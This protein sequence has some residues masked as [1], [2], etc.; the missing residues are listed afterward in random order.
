MAGRINHNAA[1]LI[2][3]GTGVV[4]GGGYWSATTFTLGAGALNITNRGLV[5]ADGQYV[6]GGGLLALDLT[7]GRAPGSAFVTAGAATLG[8]TLAVT[9]LSGSAGY[10][11]TT[12]PDGIIY[13][14]DTKASD[15]GRNQQL[16]IHTQNGVG[17]TWFDHVTLSGGTSD[18][19]YLNYGVTLVGGTDVVAGAMLTWYTG[20]ET[21]HGNFTITNTL[22][23]FDVDVALVN[24]SP[25]NILAWDGQS[26]T[27]TAS[28]SGT[29]ILSASNSYSGTTTV[30]GGVLS[31][32]GWT[33]STTA[34]VVGSTA[35]LSGTLTVSGSAWLGG[36]DTELYIGGTGGVGALNVSGGVVNYNEAWLGNGG[37]ASF[38]LSGGTISG[39]EVRM[40]A[41]LGGVA[42]GTISG[43]LWNTN[44][45]QFE[46]GLVNDGS[47][48][49]TMTGGTLATGLLNIGNFGRGALT[50][51]GGLIEAA[52]F[53][54]VGL[55][56]SFFQY[57]P[58]TGVVTMTGG[59]IN[60]ALLGVGMSGSGGAA[61][62][63]TGTVSLSG[64]AVVNAGDVMLGLSAG[65]TGGMSVSGG[66]VLNATGGVIVGST[67]NLFAAS[68]GDGVGALA[69]SDSGSVTAGGTYSQNAL[70]TLTL[71]LDG[72][73]GSRGAFITASAADLTSA[74]T[75]TVNA[76]GTAQFVNGGSASAL[77]N[78]AQIL[79]HTSTI[80]GDFATKTVTGGTSQRDFLTF[81]AFI[82][83]GTDYVAGS[84]LTWYSGTA[85]AHG[86][87]T[88][89]SGESFTLDAL[90]VNGTGGLG[91]V[92]VNPNNTSAWDGDTLTLT[93]SN[94][95]TLILSATNYLAGLRV[96]GGWLVNRGWTSDDL[97]VDNGATAINT[98]GAYLTATNAI[99]GDTAAGALLVEGGTVSVL[100]TLTVGAQA[101]SS[102]TVAVNGSGVLVAGNTGAFYTSVIGDSGVG[103]LNLGGD[104][105]AFFSS[106]S[107]GLNGGGLT[108][109]VGNSSGGSGTV[110]VSDNA[111]LSVTS[112]GNTAI[113]LG[114]DPGATGY[115]N[116]S[117]G[118]V[119]SVAGG[120]HDIIG[121][122]GG[123]GY[124]TVSGSGVWQAN[125]IM[126]GLWGGA[127]GIGI[128]SLGVLG[129]TG[130]GRVS[131]TGASAAGA[132]LAVGVD[133]G[134]SGTVTVSGS[135]WLDAGSQVIIGGG[136]DGALTVSESG[137]LTVSGEIL[138]G[139]T[140]P[141]IMPG[142]T[143]TGHGAVTVSG[144][145]FVG[146]TGDFTVGEGGTGAL[147]LTGNGR[148]SSHDVYFG[149]S[150]TA[151]GSGT[152]SGSAFWANNGG[153]FIVGNYGTG[154]LT[155]T[156][157]GSITSGEVN[158]GHYAGAVGSATVSGTAFWNVAGDFS[159]GNLATATGNLAI[160]DSGSIALTQQY[161]QNANSSLTLTLTDTLGYRGAFI[162]ADEASLSGT[163]TVNATGTANFVSGGSAAALA[164]GAQVL[165][166]TENGFNNRDFAS[167][168]VTGGTSQRDFLTFGAFITGGTDYVLGS[169]LAWFSA[170][171]ASHG[172]FTL[173]S[174]E[175]F[176][177]DVSL[178][179]TTA[180]AAG[181]NVPAWDGKSLTVTSSNQGTLYLTASNN[182]TGTTFV[183]GGAL[184]V[185][186][187]TGGSNG[188]IA[189]SSETLIDSGGTLT[190][191]GSGWLNAIDY[192]GLAG[193]YLVVGYNG[194]G[195]LNLTDSGSVTVEN[196]VTLGDLAGSTGTASVSGGLLTTNQF[197]IGNSGTGLLTISGGTVSGTGNYYSSLGEL[198]DGT[199]I[200][201]MRGGLLEFASVFLVGFRG[202]GELTLSGGTLSVG[203]AS[204][205]G[206]S[207]GSSGT[208]A[209]SGGL[210][211]S[212]GD[213]LVG[214][215]STGALTLSGGTISA[216]G[217][218]VLG[219]NAI[220]TATVSGSGLWTVAGDFYNGY[221]GTGAL[222]VT[223][224]GS[225]SVGGDIA[226]GVATTGTGAVSVRGS[227]L[228]S[229]SGNLYLGYD[230]SGTLGVGSLAIANSG[231]VAVTGSYV[232]TASSALALT[233]DGTL[234][235]RGAFVTAQTATV[236]GT[237]SVSAAGAA[238]DTSATLASH[239]ADAAQ[240][241]IHTTGGVTVTASG[242][243]SG[244]A[245][246]GAA[247]D[248]LTAG[249]F[250]VGGTDYVLGAQLAWFG[251]T[252][253]GY[254]GFT[255]DPNTSFNVNVTLSD[256]MGLAGSST[257]VSGWDGRSLTVTSSNSGTLILSA[258][259]TYTGSTTV[260]GGVL[261]V[262]G[263]TGSTSQVVIGPNAT[264]SGTVNVNGGLLAAGGDF[265]VGNRG[266]GLLALTAGG[267]INS[268]SDVI[269]GNHQG[270]RGEVTVS[271]S[272]FWNS[273]RD[274]IVG[275]IGA[276]ALTLTESG[277]LNAGRL[278]YLGNS[279]NS[280]GVVT[281]SG[282]ARLTA[283]EGLYV[284]NYGTGTLTLTGNGRIDSGAA[285]IGAGTGTGAATVG[286]SAYWRVDDYISVG[287]YGIGALTLAESGS[288]SGHRIILGN[289]NGSA[290]TAVVGGTARLSA[291]ED[292]YN[293]YYMFTGT[294]A[295]IVSGSGLVTVGGLYSQSARSTLTLDASGRGEND[296]FIY[297][298]SATVGGAI[299]VGGV[300]PG[301][302]FD[303]ASAVVS[304]SH[305]VLI[306]AT[307]GTIS[308]TFA[309]AT[310]AGFNGASLPDYLYGGIYKTADAKQYVAGV[311]LAWFGDAAN[312]HGN[313][314]V[315]SGTSFDV[316]VSLSDTNNFVSSGTYAGGWDGKSLTVTSSNSGTLILSASNNY[317]GTTTVN[318]GVL[319]ITGWTGTNAAG[320]VNG[321][322]VNVSGN[323]YWGVNHLTV[324]DATAGALAI[325]GS[326]A[327]ASQFMA[328]NTA[329]GSGAI[330]VSG[331]GVLTVG[332]TGANYISALGHGAGASGVLGLGDDARVTISGS[333]SPFLVGTAG[334]SGTVTISGRAV[335]ALVNLQGRTGD[336]TNAEGIALGFGDDSAGYLFI[337]GGTLDTRDTGFDSIGAGM[338][339]TAGSGFATVSGSGVWES[340]ALLAGF[341]AN[342]ADGSGL[343]VVTV[344]G[345]GR[346]S[347]AGYDVLGL[348]LGV[349]L[350]GG[351]SG[352]V[353]ISGGGWYDAGDRVVFGASGAG[354]LTVGQ[355]GSLTADSDI[356]IGAALNEF[357]YGSG[358]GGL[359][360]VSVSGSGLVA[361][362]SNFILG[363]TSG[364][365]NL[366]I[367]GSGLVTAGGVYAQNAVSSLTLTLDGTPGSR[368]AFV[369]ANSGTL[370]GTLTVNATGT[371]TFVSGGSASA[372]ANNAQVLI[373]TNTI[374]GDFATVS[375]TGG[376]SQ[377]DFLTF[378]AFITGGTDYV[379]GSQLAWFSATTASHGN[380][381][382]GAGESF[383]VDVTLSDTTPHAA[384]AN[385]I[386]W[387]G[388][389]LTV[390]ST[391]TGNL[392]LSASNNYS[393]TTTVNGGVL[394]I[395]GYVGGTAGVIGGAANT[396]GAVTISGT[397]NT[398][399]NSTNNLTVGDSGTGALT[400]LAGGM[401]G[402]NNGYLGYSN[403]GSGSATVA[404]VW[405]NRG[406]LTV[407]DR[408]AGWLDILAGGTVT[409]SAGYVGYNTNGSGSAT[410]AGVWANSGNLVVGRWSAG[411]LNILAGGTVTNSTGDV[412]NGGGG[413][414]SATV[415]GVW[416][417]R[418]DLNVGNNGTG[419]LDI[420]AG[421]TV[422]AA[423]GYLGR[424]NGSSGSANVAGVWTNSGDFTV[425]YGGKGWL[426]VTDS[427][428]VRAGGNITVGSGASTVIVSDT[429]LVT[430]ASNFI[431][432]SGGT[433]ALTVS[434]SGT[435]AAGGAYSQNSVSMLTI[436]I[437]DT[438]RTGAYIVA[439]TATLGGSLAV[440][441][442]DAS[443]TAATAGA[444]YADHT[445]LMH[446]TGG[447]I[448]GDFTGKNLD[449]AASARNYLVADAYKTNSGTDYVAGYKL[450]WYGDD[451]HATGS[452][453]L[454]G[455]ETFTVDN[456]YG[457]EPEITVNG[458]GLQ[459]RP[460]SPINGWDGQS[461]TKTGDGTLILSATNT[462][463][464]T[465]F[466]N[467]GALSVSGW[468]GSTAQVVI[469][470]SAGTSG[471]VS[472]SGYLNATGGN[473]STGII[474][475]SNGTGV[476]N[477]TGTVSGSIN[478]GGSWS[479]VAG[480]SNGRGA[481]N[482]SDSGYLFSATQMIA[483]YYGAGAVNLTG[484]GSIRAGSDFWISYV[485][486]GSGAVSVGGNALLDVGGRLV[487]GYAGTQNAKLNITD[488][489][490]VHAAGN[491]TVGGSHSMYGYTTGTV[492]VSGSGVLA[493]DA[494]F[495]L[496]GGDMTVSGADG[497][498]TLTITGSG[499]VTA[500][501]TY[502]QNARSTL[503]VSA[504]SR[505]LGDA[506]IYASSAT[507]S[508]TII[509]EDFATGTAF[510]DA[511]AVQSSSHQLL[512]STTS[513]T[514]SGV[515]TSAT[516]VNGGSNLPDYL[517]GGVYKTTSGSAYVAGVNLSWLGDT[518]N[519]TGNFT[520]S[521]GTFNVNIA[522]SDTMGLAGSSTY[523]NNWDGRSL[524][525]TSTNTGTLILSASNSYTGSTSVLGGN[526]LVTTSG[527]AAGIYNSAAALIDGGA[528]T[529]SGSAV[530]NATGGGNSFTVGSATTGALTLTDSGS[531]GTR[532]NFII[533]SATS[534]SGTVSL[535]GTAAL[536]VATLNIGEN[537]ALIVGDS[538]TG[539]LTISDAAQ[540][541]A[542][543][544]VL[545]NGTTGSGTV[546]LGGSG[547]L[548]AANGIRVGYVGAGV[549]T[550]TNNAVINSG[551]VRVGDTATGS[552]TV[553]VG[554]SA[555]WNMS[556]ISVGNSGTGWL[557]LSGGTLN[558][559][560]G[561]SIGSDAGSHG[562]ATVSGGLWSIGTDFIVGYNG[563][564]LLSVSGGTVS[565]GGAIALGVYANSSGSV[566]LSGG[567]LLT[568]S[569]NLFNGE[570]GA[571]SL[572]VSDT[573]HV[574][575][576]GSYVQSGSSSLTLTLSDTLGYRDAFVSATAAQLSGTLTVNA[577]GTA[578]FVNGGSASALANGA[579]ILI[580]TSA[581]SGDF[582][583]VTVNGGTGA[584]DFLNFGAFITGGTDYV[585]GSQ[586]AWFSATTA[587]HGNFTLNSGESF[588]VDV[589]LSNTTA[590]LGTA[591]A[592]GATWD[593]RSLTVT[594]SNSGT[595]IL[596]ASNSYSGTT[597]VL[598]GALAITGW[599][600][601][602]AQVTIGAGA[603]DSGTVSVSG[604]L[605][606][607]N[608]IIVGGS[609]AGVLN[610]SNSG[611]VSAGSTA[612][613][614]YRA[615]ATGTVNVSGSGWLGTAS[616]LNVGARGAGVLNLTGSGSVTVG[617]S[618]LVGGE[619][620]TSNAGTGAVTV[621]DSALLDVLGEINIGQQNA[622]SEGALTV[623]GGIVHGH[624]SVAIG[625]YSGRG[626]ATVSG[627]LLRADNY[628]TIGSYDGTGTL[629][630]TG[631]T[632]STGN[633][634]SVE[635][636]SAIVSGSGFMTSGSALRVSSLTSPV[637]AIRESGS[638]SVA[639]NVDMGNFGTG[640]IEVS[641]S[642]LLAGAGNF[643]NGSTGTGALTVSGSGLVTAS[644]VYSQN[645]VSSLTLDASVRGLNDAFIYASSATV[646][647]TISVSGFGTGGN[648]TTAS[649]VLSGSRQV[650]ISATGAGASGTIS[651]VF[652]SSTLV[653]FAG[654]LPD[655]LYGGIYKTTDAKQY[656]AGVNLAWF[657]DA[658]NGHGNFSVASGTSFDVNVTLSD[659]M[660][661]AGSSTYVSNW[662]GRSLTVTSSNS[663]TLILSGS[664]N[665]TGTTTVNGGVLNITGW[666]GSTAEVIIGD[667]TTDSG[668]VN[669]NG[670]GYLGAEGSI[671]VGREGAGMLLVNGGTVLAQGAVSFGH[672]DGVFGSGSVAGG[673]LAGVGIY[674]GGGSSGTGVLVING[675]TVS[676]SNPY[677]SG[678]VYIGD[679]GSGGVTLGGNGLLDGSDNS[680]AVGWGG[681]TGS[682]SMSSG[683]ARGHEVYIGYGATGTVGM[684][685][686]LLL[687]TENTDW[688][689]Y[690]GSNSGT[691]WL[692]VSGGTAQS[693]GV[694]SIGGAVGYGSGYGEVAISGS[695]LMT[696]AGNLSVG[697]ESGTGALTIS[698][699][700]L[701]T[702]GGTYF[703]NGV[704][705]LNISIGGT[706]GAFVT[707]AAAVLDNTTLNVLGYTGTVGGLKASELDGANQ[708][709][710]HT[711][712]TIAGD[713]AT[714]NLGG[715]AST[716]DYLTI[717][718]EKVNN[719]ADYEIGYN[720]TWLTG[721]RTSHG[722]FTLAAG[723][724]FEVDVSLSTTTAH[725][726]GSF[727]PAWDGASLTLTAVN[728]GLLTLSASNTYTGT[729]TVNGGTLAITGWT[730]STAAV[731]V[732]GSAGIPARVD[733]SGGGYLG[734]ANGGNLTVGGS[735]AGGLN[736]ASTGT[737]LSKNNIF[738]GHDTGALGTGTVG[739]LLTAGGDLHVGNSGTGSLDIEATGTVINGRGVIGSAP[740]AQG[741]VIVRG[742]WTNTGALIVGDAGTG[743]LMVTGTGAAEAH[744]FVS[745]G[746]SGIGT[747]TVSG[748]G[749]L[750]AGADLVLGNEGR[751]ALTVTDS[752]SVTTGTH[753][754]I[755]YNG[756]GSL[757]ISGTGLVTAGGNFLNGNSG[758]GSLSI[759]GSGSVS[760]G[761]TYSQSASSTLSLDLSTRGLNDAFI[762]AAAAA[763]DGGLIVA[764]YTG[765]ASGTKASE[766]GN[767]AQ[768]LI[769]TT[770]TITGDFDTKAITGGTS[771]VD[772][773]THSAYVSGG[774]NYVIGSGLTWQSGT[775]QAHG[776]FTVTS[777]TFEVDV[778]LADESSGNTSGWNGN[779][780]IK[781]GQ[782]TLVL[783]ASNSYSGSTSVQ[784]GE[785]RVTHTAALGAGLV[786]IA[787]GAVLSATFNSV[788]D[789][790][791]SNTLNGSGLLSVDLTATSNTF[792]F[793]PSV[794]QSG[795]FTGTARLSNLAYTLANG[796]L[797]AATLVTSTGAQVDVATGTHTLAGLAIDGG[798]VDF[799]TNVPA[800]IV[801]PDFIA[802]TGTIRLVS[803]TVGVRIPTGTTTHT[804]PQSPL[805]QQ[806]EGALTRLASSATTIGAPNNI[807]LVD[808]NT[809]A[810][811]T[812]T[813]AAAIVQ[814]GTQVAT[815]T[816]G[817][818]LSASD[819][820]GNHGL[821]A[822]Y[823][824]VAVDI[825]AGRTLLLASDTTAPYDGDEFHAVISGS[826]NLELDATQ[827][828][829]LNAANS[830]TGT[831]TIAGGTII[832]G[833]NDALGHTSWLSVTS[834]AAYDL[835]ANTQTIG[836]GIIAGGLQGLSTGSLGLGGSVDIT[837]TNAGFAASVGVT[838]TTTLH[839][840]HA[841]GDSGTL[842]I[843]HA[844]SVQLI[845]STGTFSKIIS[846][847]GQFALAAGSTVA[848]TGSNT[849]FGGTF[850]IAQDTALGAGS[851]ANLGAAAI[852]D[853]GLLTL[854]NTAAE[855]LANVLGGSGTFVK[856]G[857]GNLTISQSNAF[858]GVTTVAGGTLTLTD[859]HGVGAGDI[860]NHATLDLAG[861]G[862]FANNLLGTGTTIIDPDVILTGSNTLAAWDVTS[863][864]TATVTQQQN[865]GDAATRIDGRLVI[866]ATGGWN[867]GNALSGTGVLSVDTSGS[868]FAFAGSTGTA[869]HGTLAL[870]HSAFDLSGDNT[871]A[872][873]DA[874][875]RLDAASH[876]AV[877]TGTQQIGNLVLGSGTI[878]F[879]L[880]ASG[881]QADGIVS[882]GVLDIGDTV[883]RIDTGS[884]S[885]NNSSPILQQDEGLSLQLIASDTLAAGSKTLVTGS[886]LVDQTGAEISQA[887]QNNIV[888]SG[889]LTASGTYNFA[890]VAGNTGLHLAYTLTDLDLLAGRTTVLDHETA[891]LGAITGGTTPGGH[892]L[893]AKV[894]GS[895]NLQIT[896]TGAIWLNNA[897]NAYSGTTLVTSGTLVAGA[898]GALG[899]TGYL[900]IAAGA[901]L[902]LNHTAQ[903]IG[904]G[905]HVAG[906]DGLQGTGTL[907]LA[908]GLFDVLASNTGFAALVNTTG[909]VRLAHVQSLGA[910]GAVALNSAAATLI[911]DPAQSGTFATAFTGSQGTFI[912]DGASTVTIARANA[913]GGDAQIRTGTLA[914]ADI[915]A[916]G[917]ASV[918]ISAGAA[919][920]Y[921]GIASGAS[922]NTFSGSG[923]LSVISSTLTL[924]RDNTMA[925]A[926]LDNAVV[927]MSSS[928]ALG[929]AA[930]VVTLN[931][932][933][934][935]IR[936][937]T[938]AA[939]L[940]TLHLNGGALAFVAPA[941]FAAGAA[942]AAA[943]HRARIG[944]LG[945][946]AGRFELN[947]DFTGAAG[948]MT[949]ATGMK[950]NSLAITNDAAGTHQVHI[951]HVGAPGGQSAS[952]E[953][954]TTGS[955]LAEFVLDTNNG[956]IDFGLTA[957][958]LNRGDDTALMP[959]ANNWYLADTGLSNAA[960]VILDTASTIP[961]DWNI[962]LDALH[963]R[964]GEVRA[965]N[966]PGTSLNSG[967]GA[968]SSGNL[969]VRS[970][971]YRL[972]ATNSI[973]GRGFDQYGWG[974]TAGMDKRFR[975]ENAANLL[976]AFIDAGSIHR[977]FDLRGGNTSSSVM[978]GAYLTR[979]HDN[980][981][982]ADAVVRA[983]RY[984]NRID[985]RTPEL[986]TVQGR[987]TSRAL[988]GSVE[989]GRRLQRADGWWVEPALQASILW[990]SGESFDTSPD[991]LRLH[992]KQDSLRSAQYRALVRFGRQLGDSRWH[993]YGKL[994]AAA[995][996]SD[997]GALHAHDKHLSPTYD[998]KR[999]EFGLGASYRIND[1000]SQMYLDYEY[1001]RARY[1002]ERPWSINLGYRRL[1003]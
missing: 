589:T 855:T 689:M 973:T 912:K 188:M 623:T 360:T 54:D 871:A 341:A 670:S 348:A 883:I 945:A 147:L 47:A 649:A 176:N 965:E 389:S 277:S 482:V 933:A 241:L 499:L 512:I 539:L 637:L 395:S 378:G 753:F 425:G 362:A 379:L 613:V 663:G 94:S 318:G 521:G 946:S 924:A 910:T 109:V 744:D 300:G 834:T 339:A 291:G 487:I 596:S 421:G 867:Y 343:G 124:A 977:D 611:S 399:T 193:G 314:S 170:T 89:N 415:A 194:F 646:G 232:Q 481:I 513:G 842:A 322:T 743:A 793:G 644:G 808:L 702:A 466:V 211:S 638:V 210:W 358:D 263:W 245:G 926:S 529:V 465:T 35:G 271:G 468:T 457:V 530:W 737:A 333:E 517:Y 269:L 4:S 566:S 582:A 692:T 716:L 622:A 497:K 443:G 771:A 920:E 128:N 413:S 353:A 552:G 897:A 401:V 735:G 374:S 729:T 171:T 919:F 79:I 420:L 819:S 306:S 199:G 126:V 453:N 498:G 426:K 501:G 174:G 412:G 868:A 338:G 860:T 764:N 440:T 390:T 77:A 25:S 372:L 939:Q 490:T 244:I 678:G 594:S 917:T 712:G 754:A 528:A 254:G 928:H 996:D 966:L 473:N 212:G 225:V 334:G 551:L 439:Q 756:L 978:L 120:G 368:S 220:G 765:T 230:N 359:G 791:F 321:G 823:G 187:T 433:G 302:N 660:G 674:F 750:S 3:G 394:A 222:A 881:T 221:Y 748:S 486:S 248:Y 869:F 356:I 27:L 749:W 659:T 585:L 833:A 612:Y 402:D 536:G 445:L 812:A 290:G 740:D 403:G 762:T 493:A 864:G 774:T 805:L 217:D 858:T 832:A 317:T 600:G 682:L 958:E 731:V 619:Y 208:A 158:I 50:M 18:F 164:N 595:L 229:G 930:T 100:E 704:S 794:F 256:T 37:T 474:V 726:S 875:L 830:Y 134:A 419:R 383:D 999:V 797:A 953:L 303:N 549:F 58:G 224:S 574:I 519:G 686:G 531:I 371:A 92:A 795:L 133:G 836:G 736:I 8:G 463:T 485:S 904:N 892:E 270:G 20:T 824:L 118:T 908:G 112:V 890:G 555:L 511:L 169:E 458:I 931:N 902:N 105:S 558:G 925:F 629:A 57:G 959:G 694:I 757:D 15:V 569:G 393:G 541:A 721:T 814:A 807:A 652:V 114:Y 909:T 183:L 201:D 70:S 759:A 460:A 387:D 80:S 479:V 804:V 615:D 916:L 620:Y 876:T 253:N 941:N 967:G 922:Q 940:G 862:I 488:S 690:I 238:L 264:D 392:I 938:P 166:H 192:G 608:G 233:L 635:H 679:G 781:A 809:G 504:S 280:V 921:R 752:G 279:D 889:T 196:H 69:V 130:G 204:Y 913:F 431:L 969:W 135:G 247:R 53:M 236:G 337:S 325:T 518:N 577:S 161:T 373:H 669:V 85:T 887:T 846:G 829:T 936:I 60:T 848:L 853:D 856:D 865:L 297:A 113:S 785:L 625:Y 851:T 342:G 626:A 578:A 993:P 136:G 72:T 191:S 567:G 992:V 951:N 970:R 235:S 495:Y 189:A 643:N 971:A 141:G 45:S 714:V 275:G 719:G 7:S 160:S 414:G 866:T 51:T 989:A 580:H 408:G 41:N 295:L 817:Y 61:A 274:F 172:N 173:N 144:S 484:S 947:V 586:L 184:I 810:L 330:N 532:G 475:G 787:G 283:V 477:V 364:T 472:V 43:G 975:T 650:L 651:G 821:Y 734:T 313:F 86:D 949:P 422:S 618:L 258:S 952:F 990:L 761:G 213:F 31:V 59:T 831:T 907:T 97:Y 792:A 515:F 994:G 901:A 825:L 346:I 847:S 223:D 915:A 467:G 835:A 430:T 655:Y 159:V 298:A 381:T 304:S 234:G 760:V 294:G 142:L 492:T 195:A 581:I 249:L 137:S 452:F 537:G 507:V 944:T 894:T 64:G 964:M 861:D 52:G 242:T 316:N 366:A 859:L 653:G 988:G 784:V 214:V 246:V 55:G 262:T 6:Q 738:F 893:H 218:A 647:G 654:G 266:T 705:G 730:G 435:V 410:V 575:L 478:G 376:T 696:A 634:F 723:E 508:G 175:S 526:L 816:Y 40:G 276:G 108:L 699:S 899:N 888:Q 841:L 265:Y 273:A 310:L 642:G 311:N 110:S 28:N 434:D 377:R 13:L 683:T 548:T 775:D 685:G 131:L 340:R 815:G 257:Y 355:S 803:G 631:G 68:L 24:Q 111:L 715:A 739:G 148:I 827:S 763:L 588:N 798:R 344:T 423:T 590:D 179:N 151:I 709:V 583:S 877:G 73:L 267:V 843:T 845:G 547:Q 261:E 609:G 409:N 299:T 900:D 165:I 741:D 593:G 38:V 288:L 259:N 332:G 981:W 837:S 534:A 556:D 641:G 268:G 879:A 278:V 779:S 180:H 432:G 250:T 961:L 640:S 107:G 666:T 778:T 404:G 365:G 963:L 293:G 671:Y 873:A 156:D 789:Y 927:T 510:A 65:G 154:A 828:I 345:N 934:S 509:V 96:L 84:Q 693:L 755:G 979:L 289:Y 648:F 786:D 351:N 444:I 664:N 239:L 706:R 884:F 639:G 157:S 527:S 813:Q 633:Y 766:L 700:G 516:I 36:A 852:A 943:Y 854:S 598:G 703:Q 226:I 603:A 301:G 146:V 968:A 424:V 710:I 718:G 937:D 455:G 728:E 605:G 542:T 986:R 885:G 406:S 125:T 417:N 878:T 998:G 565:A 621:G 522:L 380:F 505:G 411:W 680:F 446:M 309:T 543:T 606:A 202:A 657:G 63:G 451:T 185:T 800:D 725:A 636:G 227:A 627:G 464:G 228:L 324:G 559:S 476:L 751:G 520:V 914:A 480:Y 773:L 117:G 1003:W 370:G 607:A 155:L 361:T 886:H 562:A 591:N 2:N 354:G 932:A 592:S 1002:Y 177:V 116:V 168:I 26:L 32:T 496:G 960:D 388:R 10:T 872:L 352:T 820:A 617:S 209:V 400:I 471:T 418:N 122:M 604:Y 656:V 514:I 801:S 350:G 840:T 564:G 982:F 75:L 448:R 17:G 724:N 796:D 701:V 207:A 948:L 127:Q 863:T 22:G 104:A 150:A 347:A 772:Y 767:N 673:Y 102:G 695:G 571:G 71:T 255:L 597:S 16:L 140:G 363:S 857:A 56:L 880:G 503:T 149:D 616:V 870:G 115:L 962:A 972:N 579:Q 602:T 1001:A 139:L 667:T 42:T 312:G 12:G 954:I 957:Y 281:V 470:G 405:A 391:N 561:A 483:G 251:D 935:A 676:G 315:A 722:N 62:P 987:Y 163:L 745:F 123:S 11:G 243:V 898:S 572:T 950:A 546:S 95:G 386:A 319:A 367:S 198:A 66:A 101:G 119:S 802:A 206:N 974:L 776:T 83:G 81:G 929:T 369:T 976:G 849:A 331:N 727:A 292:F 132:A 200:V 46:I 573:A 550:A 328:G 442:A 197:F 19:D 90:T 384:G 76:S 955:G 48:S 307:T 688:G 601:S 905:G 30:D 500:G 658:A 560:T 153:D 544:V 991:N 923:A 707:A 145:G 491:V 327:V 502:A 437:T 91:L 942:P 713:F 665:Y 29:L 662:D 106:T 777:G 21:S 691:G 357:G 272:A 98:D 780:L 138:V 610:I 397:W 506:F 672:S 286:G 308:G 284:A 668:T 895:G 844:G 449:L 980:G 103:V 874:T 733:V 554:G 553:S 681:G 720:L 882:T 152:V 296:A 454:A 732:D 67:F 469:G 44:G 758:T 34:V 523:A 162:T 822:S 121:D 215:S 839:N 677:G 260:N 995:V 450:A 717:S 320:L 382:L 82:T 167:K 790:T 190:V 336:I 632:V 329:T 349:G 557:T 769:H 398:G 203:G 599:T 1000:F 49:L 850:A 436:A 456:L 782:G 143:G 538:G 675:G 438:T 287:E 806:D 811:V 9:G 461:L 429:A 335:L 826:G 687:A 587:S 983:G 746:D 99:I 1:A 956:K 14:T 985:A 78:N 74:G 231:S 252:N 614:G 540:A 23:Y 396:N 783:S 799:D 240:V 661:L 326:V 563:T 533:G 237:V 630:V 770:S 186:T 87:F 747:G 768:V 93:A 570:S 645:A 285:V 891:F 624:S 407:G 576:S 129:I 88:L 416:V 441:G 385:V 711:T 462:Y 788:A 684:S 584:K 628:L 323:G 494:G 459:N 489:G 219:A 33:G 205:L 838:G 742:R 282:S 568:G 906:T 698:D 818:G 535:G 428:T 525:V 182:Y 447:T 375:V 524:T 216:G 997:G 918:A 697:N 896:A 5:N 903:T 427:G 984:I 181:A 911:L 305:Q 39:G 545:G 178:S 708:L